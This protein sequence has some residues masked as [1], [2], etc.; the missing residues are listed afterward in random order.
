MAESSGRTVT[1]TKDT[2][3]KSTLLADALPEDPT[4]ESKDDYEEIF[5]DPPLKELGLS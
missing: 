4:E 1:Y 3:R 2:P 5:E